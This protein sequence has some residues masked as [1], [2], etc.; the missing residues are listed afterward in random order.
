MREILLSIIIPTYNRP[1]LLP[2]A[3]N[4]ALAQTIEDFE[5]IVVDDCSSEPVNLPKHP[6]LRI[7]Q[8][9]E[10]K[11]VSAARNI[12][13]KAAQGRWI[14]YL[15]DDD[16]LLPNMAQVSLE[17]LKNT[18]L[19]HPIAVLSAIEVVNQQRKVV[20]TRIPPTLPRGSHFGLE[21]INRSQSFLAKQTLVVEKEV[22]LSIGGFDESFVSRETT[23]LFLRLNL[24]CS[25]LGI[26][27]ITY[28]LI[29]HEGFHLSQDT[30]RQ[31]SLIRLVKKHR[32]TFQAHPQKFADLIYNEV[33]TA[34]KLGQTRI[35]LNNFV[36]AVKINPIHI[37]GRL[38]FTAKNLVKSIVS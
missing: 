29:K 6:H 22:F 25:I 2:R 20:Q 14:N 36:W 30:R 38:L 24:V 26:P 13:A 18:S 35:A 34:L 16:E 12:G 4:S 37:V 5:V 7:I 8:L 11:G 1:K 3:V 31:M 32:T 17:A 19:P 21:K 10:N 23:E 27:Q 9:S 33:G 28:K 15:D